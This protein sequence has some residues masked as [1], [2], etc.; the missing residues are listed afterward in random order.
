M[1]NAL[2]DML[3]CMWTVAGDHV[4][5]SIWNNDPYAPLSLR[6]SQPGV[7]LTCVKPARRL[8]TSRRTSGMALNLCC[9]WRWSQ[10]GEDESVLLQHYTWSSMWLT[11][12]LKHCMLPYSQRYMLSSTLHAVLLQDC[13]L[14][15]TLHTYFNTTCSLAPIL[16]SF[17]NATQSYLKTTH[18]PRP[19]HAIVV[20]FL[21]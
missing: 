19:A 20:D 16:Q 13:T 5:G 1:W 6:P 18:E 10:V 17:S 4:N 21:L 11:V 7:T 12:F 2:W 15:S 9:C 8:R 3:C 14:P